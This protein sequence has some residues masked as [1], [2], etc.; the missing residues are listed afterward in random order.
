MAYI[1]DLEN[2]IY[3]LVWEYAHAQ[4]WDNPYSVLDLI[5]GMDVTPAYNASIKA[6]KNVLA[7]EQ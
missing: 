7:R 2:A 5:G 1:Q 4:G 6:Y 3:E